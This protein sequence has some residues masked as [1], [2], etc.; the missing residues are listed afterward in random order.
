MATQASLEQHNSR[1]DRG[2]SGVGDGMQTA[3]K[4]V[5]T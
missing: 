4:G 2:H 5:K 1:E 3:L